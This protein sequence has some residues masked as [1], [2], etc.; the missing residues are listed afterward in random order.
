MQ[1]GIIESRES[2]NKSARCQRNTRIDPSQIETVLV[3]HEGS[4]GHRVDFG[5]SKRKVVRSHVP[6]CH[7]E[8][9]PSWVFGAPKEDENVRV[10]AATPK[11][12]PLADGRT[13]GKLVLAAATQL[14]VA[15]F[16][17][18]EAIFHAGGRDARFCVSTA[19]LR[20]SP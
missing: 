18:S 11:A 9:R 8:R 12:L 16:Q 20:C 5:Q 1:R 13:I 17:R 6:V 10:A 4:I 2:T 7:G 3:P 19:S 14:L 15:H